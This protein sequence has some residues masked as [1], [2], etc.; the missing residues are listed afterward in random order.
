[1]K[2]LAELPLSLMGEG[3][4]SEALAKDAR[5]RVLAWSY[6]LTRSTLSRDLSHEGEVN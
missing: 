5:V 1:M 3:K 2:S 4:A 6:T